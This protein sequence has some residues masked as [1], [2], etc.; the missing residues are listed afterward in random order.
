M[1]SSIS[2]RSALG[3]AAKLML[4]AGVTAVPAAAKVEQKSAGYQDAPKDGQHCAVCVHF[5]PP[6]S[7]QIVDG[8]ISPNGWCKLF[9]PKGG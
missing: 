2:R 4:L 5:T 7:C 1:P 8:T 6:S 9:A 3:H